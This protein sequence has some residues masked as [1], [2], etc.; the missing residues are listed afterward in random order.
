MLPS[1]SSGSITKLFKSGIGVLELPVAVTYHSPDRRETRPER[2]TVCGG[3]L[4]S[5]RSEGPL[6]EVLVTKVRFVK[7]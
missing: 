4:I 2:V 3:L 7:I 6:D 5:L 1:S